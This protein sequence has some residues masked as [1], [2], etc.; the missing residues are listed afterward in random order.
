M[1][2][3]D[4]SGHRRGGGFPS[5]SSC[6]GAAAV[7]EGVWVRIRGIRFFSV[8]FFS[9]KIGHVFSGLKQLSRNGCRFV[10]PGHKRHCCGSTHHPIHH[11]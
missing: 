5:L 11:G 6:A 10:C 2:V 3:V 7:V 1:R 9:A 4:G 8:Q